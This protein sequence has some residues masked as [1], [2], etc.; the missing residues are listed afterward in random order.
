MGF[1]SAICKIFKIKASNIADAIDKLATPEEKLNYA[2]KQLNV[3]RDKVIKD[4]EKVEK[5]RIKAEA[6]YKLKLKQVE[7]YDNK[8]KELIKGGHNEAAKSI[9]SKYETL[10][11]AAEVLKT[12]YDKSVENE[13]KAKI[14]VESIDSRIEM[15]RAKI[16]NLRIM[17]ETQE[18][19]ESIDP[20]VC[21][22]DITKFLTEVEDFINDQKWNIEAKQ[23]VSSWVKPKESELGLD[24]L[25]LEK[26]EVESRFDAYVNSVNKST[27]KG[28]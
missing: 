19:T 26:G 25:S 12:N 11:S 3:E 7:M 27:K 1:K 10:K 28:K 22:G 5:S 16:D 18:L 17:K 23:E 4:A 8:L 13:S 20:T 2:E 24:Q 15:A 6:N 21:M 9:F 14:A